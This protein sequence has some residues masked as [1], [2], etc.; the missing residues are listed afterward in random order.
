MNIRYNKYIYHNLAYFLKIN[1]MKLAVI[2]SRNFNDYSLVKHY[3]DKIHSIQ[4]I[5]C[6]VSGGAKGADT[7]GEQWGKENNIETIVF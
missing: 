5:T 7:Y 3:L 1:I 4:P 2:G 6:I